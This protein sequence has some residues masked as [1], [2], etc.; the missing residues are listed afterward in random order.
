MRE[1]C[2]R[3]QER[4]SDS[5]SMVE[6]LTSEL[7]TRHALSPS[8]EVAAERERCKEQE[9]LVEVTRK[10]KSLQVEEA[11]L[12][13]QLGLSHAEESKMCQEIAGFRTRLMAEQANTMLT[14]L[15]RVRTKNELE[16]TSQCLANERLANKVARDR[17]QLELAEARAMCDKLQLWPS[18]GG[19]DE[20]CLRY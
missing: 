1:D 19:K 10:F 20:L 16:A 8:C 3:L 17:M 11:S 4:L 9:K 7:A 12:K 13:D 18:K 14:E 5:E 6:E 15:A 2:E